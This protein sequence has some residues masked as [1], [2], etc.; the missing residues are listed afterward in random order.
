MLL[1]PSWVTHLRTSIRAA[2]FSQY[3]RQLNISDR[4][5]FKFLRESGYSD[6]DT[7]LAHFKR[8]ISFYAEKYQFVPS[9]KHLVSDS[10]PKTVEVGGW[11]KGLYAKCPEFQPVFF[12][13]AKSHM[14]NETRHS[15]LFA[16]KEV[17]SML[18]A[19]ARDIVNASSIVYTRQTLI[20]LERLMFTLAYMGEEDTRRITHTSNACQ[21]LKHARIRFRDAAPAW[22]GVHWSKALVRKQYIRIGASHLSFWEIPKLI[23]NKDAALLHLGNK[24]TPARQ[25]GLLDVMIAYASPRAAYLRYLL[26]VRAHNILT[27]EE[28]KAWDRI[29]PNFFPKYPY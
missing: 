17:V 13:P 23:L 12:V 21:R 14:S 10:L 18:C 27:Q 11:E 28:R 1:Q 22:S 5:L 6:M 3:G 8:A 9:F 29:A 15:G 24:L 2:F 7:A 20:V 16:D 26:T 25:N 19:F 4:D